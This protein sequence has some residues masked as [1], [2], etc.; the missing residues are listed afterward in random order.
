V[1]HVGELLSLEGRAAVV[2]GAATGIGEGIARLLARA[3]AS[4]GVLD[5]D[6][7]GAERTA[8]DIVE[9]GG[10]AV[11]IDV[12]VTDPASAE[13]GVQ[14]A[15][16]E[17]G[18]LDVV[19]NNAGSYR[20]AGSVLDQTTESWERSI[21]VN[22]ASVFYVSKPSATLM[23]AAGHGGAIINI[24]SVDGYLP[25]LGTGYDTAKAG[26]VHFT[27]SLAVDLAPHAVRVNAVAP[28]HVLVPTLEKMRSGELPPVW[29][30]SSRPT[31][32]MG[33]VMQARTRAIPLGRSGTP[34]DIASSVLFLASTAAAYITGQTL[35]VDGGWTL[36]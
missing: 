17:F 12:D 10:R 22:L 7:G 30:G 21:A 5:I 11:A 27:R 3:G 16:S 25:C 29:P 8:H 34:A 20:D 13:A 2:T 24:A 6:I 28:G 18:R 15:A 23:V 33:P 31:G 14:R 32:L 36:V 35:V 26:V 4:V 19:V 1:N 9:A